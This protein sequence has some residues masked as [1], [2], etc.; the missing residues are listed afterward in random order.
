MCVHVAFLHLPSF[1]KHFPVKLCPRCC[2]ICWIFEWCLFQTLILILVLEQNRAIILLAS[3][4]SMTKYNEGTWTKNFVLPN[5][6]KGWELSLRKSHIEYMKFR[7]S[8]TLV[9]ETSAKNVW[10][11]IR[12]NES[13]LHYCLR[14][15]FSHSSL[16][17]AAC[18]RWDIC[19][20]FW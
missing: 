17:F 16:L 7:W 18:R 3:K 6:H 4:C 5:V 11:F 2:L 12:S 14:A 20:S 13:C 10:F 19:W 8:G 15:L 1:N 9:Q